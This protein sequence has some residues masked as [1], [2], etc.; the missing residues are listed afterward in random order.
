MITFLNGS[1][2]S[3]LDEA[4]DVRR[5]NRERTM[6]CLPSTAIFASQQWIL[7]ACND[8]GRLDHDCMTFLDKAPTKSDVLDVLESAKL[9]NENAGKIIVSTYNM[10]YYYPSPQCFK[11]G[12]SDQ[13]DVGEED[14]DLLVWEK[15]A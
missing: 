9:L 1:F 13:C 3:A 2:T 5:A 10:C 4:R 6:K 14:T 7:I 11:D 15:K 12:E 8:N